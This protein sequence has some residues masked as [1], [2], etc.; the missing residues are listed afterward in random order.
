MHQ[1]DQAVERIRQQNDSEE[2]RHWLARTGSVYGIVHEMSHEETID[3]IEECYMRGAK[4]VEVMGE[5]PANPS[6]NNANMLLITLPEEKIFRK[7]LFELEQAIA[8]MSGYQLSVDEGQK[9]V[10][11]LWT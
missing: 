9:Y 2:A 10:L 4:L 5:L 3:A 6:D 7:Q 1:Y 8:D 11:L